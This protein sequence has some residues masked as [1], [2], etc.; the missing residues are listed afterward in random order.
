MTK[1]LKNNFAN[2]LTCCN[3]FCGCLAV[4]YAFLGLYKQTFIFVVIAG[5]FDFFDGFAARALKSNSKIGKEL[6]SLAD[7]VTFGVVPGVVLFT[8]LQ[9]PILG[10]LSG[11][12]PIPEFLKYTGF[13]V[14]I[15][16]AVRLAIFNIDTRQ[17]NTFI[18]VPTPINSFFICSLGLIYSDGIYTELIGNFYFLMTLSIIASAWMLMQV[19]MIALKFKNYSLNDNVFKYILIASSIL[20]FAIFGII[21]IALIMILYILLSLIEFKFFNK[22]EI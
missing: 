21:G 10:S 18:G 20:S 9:I 14:T 7:M 11:N 12:N 16:S 5:V 22:N 19:P 4:N 15:F 1:F 2:I 13:L 17:V 8:L 6:D 3:L